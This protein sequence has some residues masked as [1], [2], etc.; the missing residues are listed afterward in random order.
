MVLISQ[1]KI[2]KISKSKVSLDARVYL[3]IRYRYDT[4]IIRISLSIEYRNTRI[5]YE[6]VDHTNTRII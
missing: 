4:R 1:A 3:N 2:R 6:R 5:I